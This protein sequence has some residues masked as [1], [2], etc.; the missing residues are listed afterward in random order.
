MSDVATAKLIHFGNYF[1]ELKKRRILFS[2]LKVIGI[3]IGFV[4]IVLL[5]AFC[6]VVGFEN[7]HCDDLDGIEKREFSCCRGELEIR[8]TVFFRK[9]SRICR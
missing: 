2:V 3:G 8:G 1:M 6:T 9:K 5:S 7:S 4:I